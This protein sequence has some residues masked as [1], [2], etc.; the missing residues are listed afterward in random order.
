M[1][2]RSKTDRGPRNSRHD[3]SPSKL[4][5][6][7][8]NHSGPR[9]RAAGVAPG[10]CRGRTDQHPAAI[11]GGPLD[12]GIDADL[13]PQLAQRE[14]SVGVAVE[15]PQPLGGG[16]QFA[17]AQSAVG[18]RVEKFEQRRTFVGD[19]EDDLVQIDVRRFY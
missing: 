15:G 8:R 7:R 1:S 6:I 17:R 3:T 13:R 14:V 19:A 11:V 5:S 10:C 9:S 12:L 4:R 2:S 16:V 18:P